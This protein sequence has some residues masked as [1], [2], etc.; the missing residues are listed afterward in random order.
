MCAAG[1]VISCAVT[2]CRTHSP[3]RPSNE[4]I[5]LAEGYM[6]L[7]EPHVARGLYLEALRKDPDNG[8][9]LLGLGRVA[10][11]I[12]DYETAL[13]QLKSAQRSRSLTPEERT[14]LEILLGRTYARLGKYN[15][16]WQHLW[17]VWKRGNVAVKSSLDNDIKIL[18]RT[19]PAGTPGISEVV[20]FRPPPRRGLITSAK[21]K[22]PER[23]QRAPR[24]F[25]VTPRSAWR[26]L[27]PRR[28]RLRRMSKPFRITVHHSAHY[29][30]V[31]NRPS[32]A[33]AESIRSIQRTHMGRGWGDIGYHF[34]IDSAGRIWEGRSLAY[35]GA[36]AGNNESNRGNIGIV[37]MG[38]FNLH[39][40]TQ[41]QVAAL[42]WLIRNLRRQYRISAWQIHGHCH[43]KATACPGTYLKR[44][45]PDLR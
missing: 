39:P 23:I 16:A 44:L 5:T 25:A 35:Q 17:P 41:A 33:A 15:T 45:L 6:V 31:S 8:W 27:P 38:N 32:V 18:A 14:T 21:P 2:G 12:G 11:K 1:L 13:G 24:F 7:N 26:P 30:G 20:A 43:Y 9:A 19:L 4:V 10:F 29:S 34:I 22:R 37:A 40:P 36:H 3:L 28:A 42:K